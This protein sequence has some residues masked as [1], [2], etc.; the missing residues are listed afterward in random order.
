[1]IQDIIE[2]IPRGQP[3][4][5]FPGFSSVEDSVRV[6][7]VSRGRS[8]YPKVVRRELSGAVSLL[9]QLV[10]EKEGLNH[11]ASDRQLTS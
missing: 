5:D 10:R 6:D 11:A 8:P 4:P 9:D 3:T 1:M 7:D 2:V